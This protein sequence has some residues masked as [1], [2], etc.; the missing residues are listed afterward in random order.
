MK[1]FCI[2]AFVYRR[3]RNVERAPADRSSARRLG[4]N[5]RHDHERVR[6]GF[7]RVR[8]A[9]H[10]LPQRRSGGDSVRRHVA[11]QF[12]VGLRDAVRRGE[13][14]VRGRAPGGHDSERALHRRR[15]VLRVP[16][17]QISERRSRRRTV[18]DGGDV[19]VRIPLGSLQGEVRQVGRTRPERGYHRPGGAGVP[20]PA[21][22][23]DGR[24]VRSTIQRVANLSAVL[25]DRSVDRYRDDQRAAPLA[26][27]PRGDRQARASFAVAANHVL[28]QQVEAGR[29][30]S[31]KKAP[32]AAERAA[33]AAVLVQ[34]ECRKNTTRPVQRETAILRAVSAHRF[35]AEFPTIWQHAGIQHDETLGPA[36]LY[37][38]E[39]FRRR[40]VDRGSG[41]DH[42]RDVGRAKDP[43]G[44]RLPRLP[45]F[46]RRLHDVD[47]QRA[48][49]PKVRHDR[50]GGGRRW[51]LR[52]DRCHHRASKEDTVARR[53]PRIAGELFRSELGASSALYAAAVYR[54]YRHDESNG[55]TGLSVL[56]TVGNLGA[57]LGNLIFSALLDLDSVAAFAGMG[58]LL[59]VCFCLSFFQPEP[60]KPSSSPK[61]LGSA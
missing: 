39:Q 51:I 3:L 40:E 38:S 31:D 14:S 53:F 5:L 46:L 4:R 32:R 11:D 33:I 37:D 45:G 22:A 13:E 23:L 8:P 49:L 48:G 29:Y 34:G 9:T 50:Y 25:R 56:T 21:R 16:G 59:L 54:R 20:D 36:P 58:C 30:V 47:D 12:R 57:V 60:V 26:Q 6:L 24:G 19:L 18:R 44:Q 27:V 2:P 1:I 41:A 35:S 17:D 42:E 55:S 61:S 15:L 52:W 43:P 10:L 7:R 28:R